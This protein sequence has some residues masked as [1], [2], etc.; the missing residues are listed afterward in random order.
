MKCP[1]CDENFHDEMWQAALDER[2][3]GH[4]AD[5]EGIYWIRWMH[6]PSPTCN[7]RT[8]WLAMVDASQN[9]KLVREVRVWPKAGNRKAPVEVSPKLADD[10]NEAVLV[11]GDSPKASAALSRRCL[12]ALLREKAG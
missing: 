1:H 7:K 8:I 11:L 2:H 4:Q 3:K 6:C 5:A 10:F 12:Q 9:Y